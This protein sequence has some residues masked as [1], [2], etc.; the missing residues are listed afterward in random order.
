MNA[1]MNSWGSVKDGNILTSSVTIGFSR[2]CKTGFGGYLVNT[3]DNVNHW[4]VLRQE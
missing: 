2:N 1:V 4:L 3:V